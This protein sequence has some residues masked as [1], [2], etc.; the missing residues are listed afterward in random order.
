MEKSTSSGKQ[1]NI[2][3]S[4][5]A[6]SNL[7][8]DTYNGLTRRT[9][10]G[11]SRQKSII[12]LSLIPILVITT[13]PSLCSRGDSKSQIQEEMAGTP[14]ITLK[15]ESTKTGKPYTKA[16]EME[17]V[18]Y[19]LSE[20]LTKMLLCIRN[21]IAINQNLINTCSSAR[22]YELKG[23]VPAVVGTQISKDFSTLGGISIKQTSLKVRNPFNIPNEWESMVLKKFESPGYPNGKPFVEMVTV[24]DKTVYR[25]MKPIYI[26]PVCLPCHGEKES[27]SKDIR[28]FLDTR[29]P[30]DAAKGYKNGDIRGGI[31]IVIPVAEWLFKIE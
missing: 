13:I 12:L 11:L 19:V 17:K 24:N 1:V 25:Y 4:T 16:M 10:F 21:V 9:R 6:M 29:Y 5:I 27:I 8:L 3:P 26:T 14:P 7:H 2:S 15:S 23:F 31:S 20:E 18:L 28:V 30:K 22:H